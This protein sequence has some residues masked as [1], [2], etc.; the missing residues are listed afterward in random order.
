MWPVV[1]ADRAFYSVNLAI[2]HFYPTWTINA[3]RRGDM[4]RKSEQRAAKSVWHTRHSRSGSSILIENPV[5]WSGSTVKWPQR[6]AKKL[7]RSWNAR[8]ALPFC[9]RWRLSSFWRCGSILNDQ[10]RSVP[11]TNKVG[12]NNGISFSRPT[13][14]CT[15]YESGGCSHS[16][17]N[18][19]K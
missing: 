7:L 13:K 4:K 8:C 5:L 15:S 9:R 3:S 17:E 2:T 1:V 18:I 16:F 14:V 12:R 10:Q 6:A 19:S 11:S